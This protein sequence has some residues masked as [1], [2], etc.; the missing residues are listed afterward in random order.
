MATKASARAKRTTKSTKSKAATRRK[1]G[2]RPA[3]RGVKRGAARGRPSA[4]KR[5]G[6]TRTPAALSRMAKKAGTISTEQI[7][8]GEATDLLEQDHREVEAFFEQFEQLDSNPDKRKLVS[9]ICLVLRIH[10]QI[11]EE[12]IYPLARQELDEEDL[13][14]EAEVEHASA[15]QLIAEIEAMSPRDKLFDAKVKVLGEYVK[16]HVQ[17]EESELF[18]K[19]KEADLDFYSLGEKVAARKIALLVK[20]RSLGK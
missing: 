11:E 2:A 4:A 3:K 14:D 12:L 15:K 19:M 16:H 17:E 20:A 7:V 18:P 5:K 6:P 8:P 10:A 1:S 9:K 13:V